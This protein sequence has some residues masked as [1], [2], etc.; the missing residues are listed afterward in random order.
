LGGKVSDIVKFTFGVEVGISRLEEADS[1]VRIVLVVL[2]ED[3]RLVS[4]EELVKMLSIKS[5][6]GLLESN[7][8]AIVINLKLNSARV[9]VSDLT[10]EKLAFEW[11]PLSYVVHK[12]KSREAVYKSQKHLTYNLALRSSHAA[13]CRRSIPDII[14]ELNFLTAFGILVGGDP[15]ASHQSKTQRKSH[16]LNKSLSLTVTTAHLSK[17]VDS[18]RRLM[19]NCV[20]LIGRIKVSPHY[21]REDRANTPLLT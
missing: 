4:P 2:G 14:S 1:V 8:A 20:T 5:R 11:A 21:V 18:N 10:W 19:K 17:L 15:L 9:A 7:I 6:S 12:L 3:E 16:K 13:H